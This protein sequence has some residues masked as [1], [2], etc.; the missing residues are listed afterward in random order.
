MNARTYVRHF[1]PEVVL[2]HVD[3]V[4][5][6]ARVHAVVTVEVAPVRNVGLADNLYA[7]FLPLHSLV[8]G[9]LVV[10]HAG[11]AAKHQLTAL[12]YCN[13]GRVRFQNAVVHVHAEHEG[14]LLVEYAMWQ[15]RELA[16]ED[17]IRD[18]R[19]LLLFLGLLQVL[20]KRIQQM[21]NDVGRHDL[22]A[23]NLRLLLG[24]RG[25][26]D[27][28]G[29]D[30]GVL[31]IPLFTHDGGLL[32]VLFLH[33]PEVDRENRNLLVREELE[34]R[35]QRT[36]RGGHDVDTHPSAVHVVKYGRD[37]LHDL[38]AE[39]V[40][41]FLVFHEE[42]FGTC[43]RFLKPLRYYLDTHCRLYAGVLHVLPLHSQLGQ[44]LR[45]QQG[46]NCSHNRARKPAYHHLVTL[47]Y[48]AAE[49][50]YVDSAELLFV[51]DVLHHDLLGQ[52]QDQT[53][54]VGDTLTGDGTRRT[55]GNVAPDV[56]V[57]PIEF[58]VQPLFGQFE[59]DFSGPL[60]E[61]SLGVFQLILKRF[62]E[63][64]PRLRYPL[65]ETIYFVQGDDEITLATPQ[66]PDGFYC[67][68]LETMHDIDDKNGDITQ[69][70]AT[71][72]QVVERLV[73]RR[74][75]NQKPRALEFEFRVDEFAVLVKHVLGEEGCTNLLRDTACFGILNVAVADFVQQL[76]LSSI[77]VPQNTANR[78]TVLAFVL[79]LR[80]LRY[81]CFGDRLW[82][83]RFNNLGFLLHLLFTFIGTIQLLPVVYDVVRIAGRWRG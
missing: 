70:G 45:C 2:K 9:L 11:N 49:E 47:L 14:V 40:D 15:D 79:R 73:P 29:E 17:H 10:L 4:A 65:V 60:P 69:G 76:G 67:L 68:R 28:E 44:R 63:C 6:N 23:K 25:A 16:R 50:N 52:L 81:P 12:G 62:V 42:H 20:H 38:L 21:V 8:D 26:L 78:R 57:L 74:V 54:E 77:Y 1:V 35:L 27:V 5:R 30:D 53:D 72:T 48:R 41:V 34:Q 22:H 51:G 18:A 64:R 3:R 56:V 31:R 83:W 13:Q 46:A 36:Q 58:A 7:D 19:L 24:F 61:F 39:L 66:Q 80:V 75:N 33:C 59:H 37:V 71:C 32:N 82:R 55:Y 43:H